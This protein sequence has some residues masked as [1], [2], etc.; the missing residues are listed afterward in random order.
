MGWE[1]LLLGNIHEQVESLW[2]KIK[3]W[4]NKSHFV[5]GV[6]Y[7]QPVQGEPIDKALF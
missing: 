4:T 6:Y 1:E 3:D 5:I 2:V 7:R